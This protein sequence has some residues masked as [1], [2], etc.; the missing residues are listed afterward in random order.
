MALFSNAD[1]KSVGVVDV[2]DG[3]PK[4]DVDD[5]QMSRRP[6]ALRTSSMRASVD[7]SDVMS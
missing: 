3:G 1:N 6:Q 5:V 2:R 4:R 7:S